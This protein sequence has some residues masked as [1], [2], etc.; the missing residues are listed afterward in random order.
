MKDQVIYLITFM[1][2]PIIAFEDKE[3]AEAFVE[4]TTAEAEPF[5]I[6]EISYFRKD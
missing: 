3:E 5:K 6:K 4:R 2:L 1:D